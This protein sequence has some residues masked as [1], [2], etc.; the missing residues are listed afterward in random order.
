[1]KPAFIKPAR[2]DQFAVEDTHVG[3]V[4]AHIDPAIGQHVGCLHHA[5]TD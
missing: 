5:D 3:A 4:V 1:M 2:I